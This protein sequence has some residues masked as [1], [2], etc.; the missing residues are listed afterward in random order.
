MFRVCSGG[1]PLSRWGGLLLLEVLLIGCGGATAAPD[2]PPVT[3]TATPPKTVRVAASERYQAGR[4]HRFLFGGGYRDLWKAQVE[5]PVLDLS[6]AGGGLTPTGRFGGLQSAV[7]G[8][9]G[10]DG[11]RY[12]FRG[13]DKDP[14]A[15]LHPI[16]R[17]SPVRDLVQD[18]MAAQHPGG[19]LVAS[20]LSNAAGILTIE[21]RMVVM[22]DDPALGEF[23]EEFAG[24]VGSFYEYPTPKAEGRQG[25][26]GATE[27]IA[28]DAL[29]ERISA[30]P[31]DQVDS[32]AY[33]R[34]RLFDLLLGDFDRHR[35]QWRWAKL[36]GN[37]RWQPIPEDR[38]Q[39]FVRY[40]GV[41]QRLG[42]LYV[43]IL[44][45]YGDSYPSMR[46]LVLHGWEQD[47]WLLSSLDWPTWKRIT[48]DLQARLSDQVIEKALRRLPSEY[49]ALDAERLRTDIRGRRDTWLE[50]ARAFYEH[51]A[52]EINVQATDAAEVVSARWS[53][54]K[55]RVE[56]RRR[57]E[58]ETTPFFARTFDPAETDELRIYLKGG[59]DRVTVTGDA[60]GITLRIISGGG[61]KLLDDTQSGRAIFY[62][63][64]PPSVVRQGSGTSVVHDEYEPPDGASGFLE[65]IEVPPRD[66]GWEVLPFPELGYAPGVGFM[67]G[68]GVQVSEFGFRKHPWSRSHRATALFATGTLLPTVG[69]SGRYRFENSNLVAE[70]D[71][72]YDGNSIIRFH[73]LGNESDADQPDDFYN[74]INHRVSARPAISWHT[75]DR[76]LRLTGGIAGSY[77]S[78]QT[79]DGDRLIGQLTPYGSGSFFQASVFGQMML[80]LRRSEWDD[81]P[82]ALP[83]HDNR[84]AGYATQGV[85]LDVRAEVTPPL[86]SAEEDWGALDASIAGY[87]GFGEGR[88][89]VTGRVGERFTWGRVPYFGAAYLGGGG[90]FSGGAT[91]RGFIAQRFAG[92][93]SLYTNLD[94]RLFLFRFDLIVPT[95]LGLL[96]FGDVGRVFLVGESSNDWHPSAGGGIWLAPLARTNTISFSVA[97]SEEKVNVYV[98]AG[99]HY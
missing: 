66:W 83:L 34:A 37:P 87:L 38:D 26:H 36:P 55:L 86:F 52:A 88:F 12:T 19:P 92:D 60:G 65:D 50:G 9:Q 89:V 77:S 61:Q 31:S 51:L 40:D 44:Q 2:T 85:L 71:A 79:E 25:F 96:G 97:G 24:M 13:T 30:D 8:L 99:F 42:S 58:D 33:L 11:K 81:D 27:I 75:P 57:A 22:P 17:D 91:A 69:Y 48:A 46:G 93:A 21:E 41:G 98:R 14:S 90:F 68:A 78:T 49:Y 84:S 47:R 80:D 45:C 82:L 53:D 76:R 73:G 4:L 39:A 15:V 62:D 5:L 94:L 32:E 56:V 72:E 20:A 7:L 43:P 1:A 3:A 29:Y 23:R 67:L 18:Q 16:L 70:I 54:G 6:K 63:V 35:K 74:V 64:R 28:H 95:D 59:D 10:P